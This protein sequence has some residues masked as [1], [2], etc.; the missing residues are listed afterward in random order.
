[1]LSSMKFSE[2]IIHT[3]T[4]K[5]S[6]EPENFTEENDL[7]EINPGIPKIVR[8]SVTDADATDSSSEEGDDLFKRPRVKKF[9]N[10]ITIERCSRN[11]GVRSRSK[12]TRN[13]RRKLAGKCKLPANQRLPKT[14]SSPGGRKFRGVRQRPWGKWAAEIRDPMRRVRLWLGTYNTAEEA[15]MVYDSAAIKLRGPDALTNFATPLLEAKRENETATISAADS[16]EESNNNCKNNLYS[17]K[18]VLRYVSP[19]NEEAESQSPVQEQVHENIVGQTVFSDSSPFDT[20]FPNDLFDF[21]STVSDLF[22]E[23]GFGESLLEDN[24]C[25]MFFGSA[26]D[27]LPDLSTWRQDD[28]FQDIGDL[29]GSDPRV[30]L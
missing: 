4:V 24:I 8:V 20:V 6:S 21:Q 15:A 22:G 28:Y 27:F 7:P 2:H 10:E 19:S 1:M 18:S 25:D 12:T 30:A 14:S 9:V 5:R 23:V 11:N 13:C 29:F 17:P 16:S 3:T 26:V